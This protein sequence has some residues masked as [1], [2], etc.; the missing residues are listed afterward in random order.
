MFGGLKTL[1]GVQP[2]FHFSVQLRMMLTPVT[3]S[4]PD[5]LCLKTLFSV[6]GILSNLISARAFH[7]IVCRR[8]AFWEDCN[9]NSSAVLENETENMDFYR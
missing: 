5:F 4:L 6:A 2:D 7:L 3:K 9:E 1:C 8:C